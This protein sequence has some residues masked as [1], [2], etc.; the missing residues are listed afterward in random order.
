MYNCGWALQQEIPEYNWQFISTPGTGFNTSPGYTAEL[1]DSLQS[2]PAD[3][4]VSYGVNDALHSTVDF[5]TWRNKL[6]ETVAYAPKN[7][8]YWSN[9]RLKSMNN[10][11][12]RENAN[13]INLALGLEAQSNPHLHVV[14]FNERA[15]DSWFNDNL[16]PD[17]NCVGWADL[18]REQLK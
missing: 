12:Q 18:Y 14:P 4:F 13:E 16:H 6:R 9:I 2:R 11:T 5:N 8:W 15:Q 17:N 7:Q 1:R 10:D 3:V